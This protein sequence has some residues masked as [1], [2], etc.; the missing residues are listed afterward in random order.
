MQMS[1]PIYF[2][3]ETCGLHGPIVLI[4]WAE[5]ETAPINLHPVWDTPIGETL[6][7]IENL[8]SSGVI[9][10]NLAFDWF[11][12]CQM[13][14]TF[15]QM[16]RDWLPIEHI[17]TYAE[18]EERAR[19]LNLCLKP[20]HAFD[21]MLHARK[22]PYQS[23]MDR[24]DIRIKR[25]PVELSQ[26][27]A[28]EL[29]KRIILNDL[30]FARKADPKRRWEVTDP[31]TDDLESRFRDI[32]LKFA[33]SSALKALYGDV[34]GDKDILLHSDV[35]VPGGN[36]DELGYAPYA[37]AIAK[38]PYWAS[39]KGAAWPAY[40]KRHAQHWGY[41]TQARKYA[42]AD[43]RYLRVLYNHFGRPALDDNDSILAAAIGAARWHGYAIN[44]DMLHQLCETSRS[45]IRDCKHSFGSTDVCKRYLLEVMSPTEQ[46]AMERDGKIST[47]GTVLEELARWRESKVCPQCNGFGCQECDAG[48]VS[49]GGK[50]P[51]A[52]RAR[53]I[54]DFR[55]AQKEINLLSKLI[56]AQ[57][58]HAS[59]KVIGALSSRMAGADGLNPQGI[60]RS[61]YIRRCFPLADD[62]ELLCGGDLDAS[63]IAISDAVYGDPKI[64]AELLAGRKLYP[65][66]GEYLF[67]GQTYEQIVATK[68]LPNEKDLYDRSKKGVLAMLF[69]GESYTLQTRVG[70][71]EEG[72]DDAYRRWCA[73][74]PVWAAARRKYFDMFCSMRQ[75]KGIGTKVEWHE[76]ADFVEAMFG[77]KRYFTL[78][79]RICKTLYDLAQDVPKEWKDLGIKVVRRDREQTAHGAVASALYA[80]AFALQASNMR[81]A[82]NHV[83]QSPEAILL[84]DLQ[85]RI[86]GIQPTGISKWVVRPM[87]VHDELQC[88]MVPEVADFVESIVRGFI[89]EMKAYIPL[90]KMG[91]SKGM[92]NWAEK[93]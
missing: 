45:K 41:N 33:P 9:A 53:E 71:T 37:L 3:T 34:T 73:D 51:V 79:N 35:D 68:G 20:A 17:D 2:D 4:Q 10:F 38:P 6:D 72:A 88:P 18:C 86:W 44:V 77:F 83:I 14:T 67:P 87:N 61:K 27:L 64:H 26:Q 21:I 29:N 48:L 85:C 90:I 8:C 25:I 7:L 47:K 55:H 43:V 5:G 1:T 58:F 23:T 31:P 16:D 70:I 82:A 74:H 76:P 36:P 84:K 93:S 12:I 65:I 50:H 46:L 32:C 59:F 11:H 22:G 13:Y 62:G 78:E 15:M 66:F 49:T 54:L 80:A 81:A 39:E 52:L 89:T 24:D 69:G 42:E 28:E 40:I 57:R 60:N 63:Q 92:A 30:Y 19:W 91:W 75:P 56:L